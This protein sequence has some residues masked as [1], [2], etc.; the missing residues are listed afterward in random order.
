MSRT[1]TQYLRKI[2]KMVSSQIVSIFHYTCFYY[3]QNVGIQKLV[4]LVLMTCFVINEAV[5]IEMDPRICV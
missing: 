3:Y 5:F 4:K 2:M 1:K